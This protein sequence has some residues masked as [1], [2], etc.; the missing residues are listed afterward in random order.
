MLPLLLLQMGTLGL[1]VGIFM[2]SLTTKYRD[3]NFLL[4][5]GVQVW[6]YATPVIYPFSMV[7]DKWK[8]LI[9]LNPM[10]SVVEIFRYGFIGVGNINWQRF[11]ISI[12][13]TLI[14]LIIGIVV[15]SRAERSFVDT[16]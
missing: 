2:S 16:V 14:C 13:F 5:M 9:A 7:P 12:I 11:G 3:L 15:F 8:W 1:G 4:G 6:F 10:V